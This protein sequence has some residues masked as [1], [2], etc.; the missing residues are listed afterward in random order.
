MM[1]TTG[2]PVYSRGVSKPD[3][4]QNII[5]KLWIYPQKCTI[6]QKTSRWTPRGGLLLRLPWDACTFVVMAIGEDWS[7]N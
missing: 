3:G 2:K 7:V 4:M 1:V 6:P 5:S